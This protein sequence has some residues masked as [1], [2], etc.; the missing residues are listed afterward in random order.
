[1]KR[2]RVD[3]A[4]MLEVKA[5][6]DEASRFIKR[7]VDGDSTGNE[8]VLLCHGIEKAHYKAREA[9]YY[10]QDVIK[11]YQIDRREGKVID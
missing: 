6:L 11:Q 5:A 2:P 4:Y 1:M 8:F 9:D 7:Y 3:H 10:L